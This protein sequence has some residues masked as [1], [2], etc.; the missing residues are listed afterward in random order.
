M[1]VSIIIPAFNEAASIEPL[2]SRLKERYPDFEIIVVN[3][4]SSDDTSACATAAGAV[5]YDHP[6]NIG[7][8]AAI[9]SGI[10][11]ARGDVFVFMD[12]DGQHS[13]EEIDSLL[14]FHPRFD[15]IV[16][17][18]K[19]QD[20]T[21]FVRF[22]G[23]KA[24]NFLASYVTKFPV[25]DLT[26]GFRVIRA[27]VAKSFLYLLPNTYSYPTTMTLSALRSGFSV[28]YVPITGH[29]RKRG[30]SNIRLL[31]DGVRF[32]MIVAKIC[33]LF[34][35]MRIFLP[36]SGIFFLLGFTRYLYTFFMY[37]RFT[38]MSGVMITT[39]VMIFLLGLVSEQ[40]SQLR[41][42]RREVLTKT[43]K[44]DNVEEDHAVE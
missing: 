12:A 8:G 38:N 18:R 7:N 34:S 44:R 31:N 43:R 32:F 16:G 9:K 15:M 6:Y 25:K 4:G 17:Q 27:D 22:L 13:P 24:L 14:S 40:I 5:V 30:S 42:E 39:A 11:L 21:S 20:Q 37:N 3:D 2:L 1:K 35:P 10:R 26:S 23:N 29:K 36:V 28:R 33:T 41:F 19:M